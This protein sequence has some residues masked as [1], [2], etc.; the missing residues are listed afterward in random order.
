RKFCVERRTHHEPVQRAHGHH[1]R[2]GVRQERLILRIA[3]V[4]SGRDQLGGGREVETARPT[5]LIEVVARRTT[6]GIERAC[7][8]CPVLPRH[9][10][11][12]VLEYRFVVCSLRETLGT[13]EVHA[14][15]DL[16]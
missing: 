7:C 1:W 9:E 16:I 5:E 3:R 2:G 12:V 6:Y 15:I 8:R 4:R 14:H 10:R 13:F 11:D